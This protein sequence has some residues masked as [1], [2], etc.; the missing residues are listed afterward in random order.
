MKVQVFYD[1]PSGV[2]LFS[3]EKLRESE[4]EEE[5]EEDDSC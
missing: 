5:V 1:C 2:K 3:R 4:A